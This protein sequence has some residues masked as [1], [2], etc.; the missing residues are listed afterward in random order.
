L[1]NRKR[2]EAFNTF[3]KREPTPV[4][5]HDGRVVDSYSEEWRLECE[6]RAVIKMET[7]ARRRDYLE[8]VDRKRGA[9]AG[10]QLRAIIRALWNR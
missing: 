2:P 8:H 5:L 6:A 7:L 4:T 9:E 1:L 3:P 10:A